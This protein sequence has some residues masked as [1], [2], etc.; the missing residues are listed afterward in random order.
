MCEMTLADLNL[1]QTKIRSAYYHAYLNWIAWR[2]DFE[3]DTWDQ[4]EV[5]S[6]DKNGAHFKKFLSSFSLARNVTKLPADKNVNGKERP[7]QYR[8]RDYLQ[9]LSGNSIGNVEEVAKSLENFVGPKG[10]SKIPP[11]QLSLASKIHCLH[12]P[13]KYPMWDQYARIGLTTLMD[14]NSTKKDKYISLKTNSY[15]C[16]TADFGNKFSIFE[17]DIRNEIPNFCGVNAS[18]EEKFLTGKAFLRRVFDN[19]LMQIGRSI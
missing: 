6:G 8:V 7:A 10:N 5:L 3:E 1:G 12:N 13:S 9:K 15:A 4:M 2:A 14:S 16:F 18:T 11:S 19:M 17:C